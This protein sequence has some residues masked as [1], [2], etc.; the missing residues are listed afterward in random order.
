MREFWACIGDFN[1]GICLTAV[2]TICF[3][4]F[5]VGFDLESLSMCMHV[6]VLI[7]CI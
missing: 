5:K 3:I 6:A 2:A 4:L 7:Y 1:Y